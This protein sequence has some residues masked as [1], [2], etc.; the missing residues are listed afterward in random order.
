MTT[1]LAQ[2][3]LAVTNTTD[4]ASANAT[5][6]N[7]VSLTKPF[8]IPLQWGA[9]HFHPRVTAGVTYDDNL[10]F[11]TT[12]QESDACWWL[13]PGFQ[14][15]LGDDESLVPL[16]DE[17][18]DPLTLNPG[19]LI[20]QP[21]D[22]WLGKIAILDYSP[23]FKYYDEYTALDSTDEFLTLDTL[24]PM[25]KLILGFRQDYQLQKAIIIEADQFAT[26]EN[27][28][29]TLSAAYQFG[30]K[31]SLESDFHLLDISYD[32]P[33]LIGY[34]EYNTE[35]WF[36]YN[37]TELM[38][39]SLGMLAG[40]DS[41]DASG[42]DQSYEQVRAR[43]RYNLSE[44]LT[45]DGSFGGEL[46]QYENGES[47]TLTPVFTLVGT[48]RL[49]ERTTLSLA[50]YRQVY[51]SIL[52]GYNYTGTGASLG[53]SQEITDRFTVNAN[54]GYYFL[55]FT[56]VNRTLA[57]YSEDY[58]NARLSLQA[59]ILHHLIG[60]VYYNLNLISS[61]SSGIGQRT[62]NQLGVNLSLTY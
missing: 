51:A 5:S 19:Y 21:P 8:E 32:L 3:N 53:C 62:D 31:T 7:A 25:D 1:A 16:R 35:D 23:R 40:Y 50:G 59:K 41:V 36:N 38:P 48:Y 55:D 61:Q 9:L 47:D 58:Y 18:I 11:T 60:A 39:V 30:D 10:L 29:T 56:A 34:T 33:G 13:Q 42:Q 57:N 22:Q 14:A 20:V 6:T 17:H 37:L 44:K 49:T 24:W 52:N 43:V 15:V 45:F 2:D 27:I 4:N 54:L 26:T 28:N 46:R 12:H